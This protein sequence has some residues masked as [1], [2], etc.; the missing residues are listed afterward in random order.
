V[1]PPPLSAAIRDGLLA[2]DLVGFHTERWAR[3]FRRSAGDALG[4][5]LVTAHPISVDPR[6]FTELAASAPVLERERALLAGRPE[7]L[8][9]RVDRTDPS[10]NVVR[11]FLAFERYL[12]LHPESLGRVG[13]LALLDPS[14]QDIPEYAAYVAEIDREVTRINARFARDGRAPIDLRVED[15]F[16]ASVAAYKQYDVLLVNAV[17]DGLNLVAK[18][19]PL[20]N[21]RDG[22]LVLSRNA[23]VHEELGEW[24]VSI[25]PLDVDGQAAAIDEALTLPAAERRRRLVG[26]RGWVESHDLEHWIGAILAD[27]DRAAARRAAAA[28]G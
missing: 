26:I 7:K 11:G 8:V 9:L 6:E 14:R 27:L 19:A 12:E 5:T 23:G 4:D 24:A 17:F 3:N 25:D 20:V 28:R 13:M 18:E 15:D 16:A 2:N 22:V 1:L 21:A 10:K